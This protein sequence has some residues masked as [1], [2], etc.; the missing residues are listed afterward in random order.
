M[1]ARELVQKLTLEE[2]LALT[3]GRNF[4]QLNAIER[5]NI[6]SITVNDGPHGLR[7][8]ENPEDIG[9]EGPIPATNFPSASAISTS[10]NT[11]L[12]EEVGRAIGEEAQALGTQV[13]LGPGIN[14]KRTPLGG[15]NFEYYSEDP[16]LAGEL[17]T[18]FVRGV[19]S[20]GV[21]TS[22][23][24]YACNNQEF[25]RM[26]ISADVDTRTLREIYLAG[27][28]RVVKNAQ[29]W[30]VMAAYNSINGTAATE[31]K[32]L[33]T[34]IL[35]EEWG[36]E[37]VVVSD[38]GAVNDKA[39]ALEA[40]L[41]L[42]MPPGV[43]R[44]IQA[45]A[46]KVRKGELSE[47]AVDKAAERVLK[48]ILRAQENRKEGT[49]FDKDAHHALARKAAGESIVLLK[50]E[51]KILP[52]AAQS[53]AVI[54]RFARQPRFQGG[55]SSMMNPTRVDNA[56]DE[57]Q[58]ALAGKAELSYADG[59]LA[60]GVGDEKL[61]QEALELAQKA[62]VAV[63]FAGLPDSYES[64]GYDRT[65]I[66]LP[67]SH[68]RLIADICRVQPNTVVVLFNG[69]VVR[70]PWLADVKAVLEAGLGGQAVA[71][72]LMC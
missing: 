15:R 56:Y 61:H 46:E 31:H 62:E 30:T 59:Y 44:D 50:N 22:L 13:V 11:E 55:G 48:L 7:K 2:K 43:G 24:H 65:H 64:E 60:E 42:E 12:V 72:L 32:E 34:D 35:K 9:L 3:I 14:I 8:P 38:W 57:L 4:W 19:Q 17:G 53:V 26:S 49:T 39:K 10:W 5:L 20:Q 51:E 28:E 18:A 27:F 67:E 52:L 6:P 63:I 66:D 54:G 23:K 25:E 33:L 21:G 47:K 58:K 69:S 29:P 40:G 41:D 36:F 16:V 70:M 71:R 45:L 1:E 37:G 68:N